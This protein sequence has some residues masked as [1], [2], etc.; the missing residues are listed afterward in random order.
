MPSRYFLN[1]FLRSKASDLKLL[2]RKTLEDKIKNIVDLIVSQ[3]GID[4]RDLDGG[5]YVGA[6]GVAYM[7]LYLNSKLPG[8]E[9]L[10]YASM[11]SR[12]C[13]LRFRSELFG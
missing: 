5:L 12:K 1:P 6:G 4:K 2:E 3:Q 8:K 13:L 7:I 10:C 11:V 9:M